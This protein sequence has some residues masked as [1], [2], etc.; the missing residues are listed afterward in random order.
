MTTENNRLSEK[1]LLKY[2]VQVTKERK[3][4]RN[5]ALEFDRVKTAG[6]ET[7]LQAIGK[8]A[9]KADKGYFSR[10]SLCDQSK[11]DDFEE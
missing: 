1:A 5:R 9:A 7:D 8:L 2:G 3:L 6:L 4:I 11:L 10:K